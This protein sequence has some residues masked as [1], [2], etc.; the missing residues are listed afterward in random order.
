M[1][2]IGIAKIGKIL[3]VGNI[4][5]GEHQRILTGVFSQ[6]PKQAHQLV[7]LL[8]VQATGT[9]NL[10]QKSHSIE[11]KDTHTLIEILAHNRHK[12]LE[13][14]RVAKIQIYL[15]M[16]ERAPD[17]LRAGGCY[18]FTQQGRGAW[19]HHLTEIVAR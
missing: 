11:A 1:G 17:I 14:F 6:C 12:L 15:I 2:L 13:Y 3:P 19:A 4:G 7:S 9:G 16:T 18:H 8:Q 5:L 10:P